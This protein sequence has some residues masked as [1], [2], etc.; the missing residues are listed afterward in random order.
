MIIVVYG[1]I[2]VNADTALNSKAPECLI[3]TS[4]RPFTLAVM[5]VIVIFELVLCCMTLLWGY[6]SNVTDLPAISRLANALCRGNL[7]HT[8]ALLLCTT[9]NVFAIILAP[10]S[11]WSGSVDLFQEVLHSVMASRI[12]FS[13][14]NA[15]D[16]EET[17][18][19]K[20]L[21]AIYF[22][23]IALVFPEHSDSF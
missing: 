14:R 3:D 13:L 6:I 11:G 21:S 23:P 4:L 20:P 12:L 19:G 17:N 9:I 2:T 7:M 1:V 5:I 8:F 10:Q 16:L 15:G 18:E 22:A